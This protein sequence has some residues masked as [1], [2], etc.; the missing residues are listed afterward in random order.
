MKLKK[1]QDEQRQRICRLSSTASRRRRRKAAQAQSRVKALAKLQPIAAQVD[2]RVVPF[3]FPDPQKTLASPL[4]R[5]EA[6]SCRLR[7]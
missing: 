4:M 3:H 2:D 1:K 7:G 5:L 6:A